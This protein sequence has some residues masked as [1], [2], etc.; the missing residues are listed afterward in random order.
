[1]AVP[2]VVYPTARRVS[3]KVKPLIGAKS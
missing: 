1:M 2:K 3:P